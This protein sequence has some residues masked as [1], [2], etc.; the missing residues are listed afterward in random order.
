MADRDDLQVWL[1]EALKANNG[2]ATLIDVCKHI[3]QNHEHEL[4]DSGDL[5]YKWQYDVRWAA[6]V[7][8]KEGVLASVD[9]SPK[10]VWKLARE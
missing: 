8:R 5:F 10:G 4:R 6:L 3:W 9:A 7:L 2:S 1:V